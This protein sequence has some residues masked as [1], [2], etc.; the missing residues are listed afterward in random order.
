MI[1]YVCIFRTRLLRVL[2]FE[3]HADPPGDKY[4]S[5]IDTVAQQLQAL[6]KFAVEKQTGGR[7]ATFA[8]LDT[9]LFS[10]S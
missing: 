6:E 1:A 9:N 2:T 3:L 10:Q 8:D 4:E 7:R 5:I